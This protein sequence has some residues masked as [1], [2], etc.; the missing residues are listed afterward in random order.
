MVLGAM[1]GTSMDGIDL[2]LCRI[3]GASLETEVHLM[4]FAVVQPDRELVEIGRSLAF[5]P[6]SPVSDILK[7]HRRLGEEWAIQIRQQLK[8]W[9]MEPASID[10]IAS[11]G[12]TLFHAPDRDGP[13]HA[14]L[15]LVDGDLLARRLGIITI[16]DF[17]QKSI[18]AGFE[19]APLAP[20][21]ESLIFGST[22][23]DRILLNLGGI[24]N[25]TVLPSDRNTS[26]P[27]FG[28]DTGPANTLLDEAV[29]HLLPGRHFDEEGS[30]ARSGSVQPILLEELLAHPFFSRQQPRST[31]QEEF[32]WTW[33]YRTLRQCAPDLQVAD[34]LAT[35]VELTARTVV[36]A[37]PA[38]IRRRNPVLYISGGGWRNHY[39]IERIGALLP[40]TRLESSASLGI[41]PDAKEAILFAVL[42]NEAVAGTGWPDSEG[43]H[44]TLG[45]ISLP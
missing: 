29:R 24:G 15:Q 28:T 38:D 2:A 32:S 36:E 9:G 19:G 17:R 42:A 20:L 25:L 45:K 23:E 39:L 6:D 30:V 41:D 22:L 18:A 10:L 5:R 3:R 26:D 8:E 7:L 33:L 12:Q 43:G 13:F 16:S 27:V 35:L 21:A 31:G 14:T 1:S 4:H 37:I 34:L 40:G 44:F 11:H